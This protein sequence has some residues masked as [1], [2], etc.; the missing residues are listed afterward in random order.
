MP[1][2]PIKRGVKF[3]SFRDSVRSYYLK[4]AVYIGREDRFVP[5]E[6]FTFNIVNELLGN[7]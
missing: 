3:F 4:L 5:S 1:L 2:K 6:G 7:Y